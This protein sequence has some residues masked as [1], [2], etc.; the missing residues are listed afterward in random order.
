[1][2]FSSK[3]IIFLFGLILFACAGNSSS[4]TPL[5]TLKA[6]TAA[7]KKKDTATMKLLLSDASIKMAEQEAKA[8]NVTPDEIIKRDTLFS[9]SQTSLKYRNERIEGDK[10]IIEVENSFGSFDPVL[11]VRE[12]GKWKIDKQGFADQMLKQVD[13]QN[14]KLDDIINQGRQ[15]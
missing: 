2:R 13:E 5:E 8:Q 11:F 12:G 14:R 3:F 7:I 10:A 9:Q 6:Y 1:M 4:S 15:P